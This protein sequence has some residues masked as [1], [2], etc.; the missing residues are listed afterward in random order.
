MNPSKHCSSPFTLYQI[1]FSCP[2]APN[3][4]PLSTSSSLPTSP[5]LPL[6]S[7]ITFSLPLIPYF[8]PC[9]LSSLPPSLLP[10]SSH[11][12]TPHVICDYRTGPSSVLVTVLSSTHV[13]CC[14]GDPEVQIVVSVPSSSHLSPLLSLLC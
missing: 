9:L 6:P 13:H 8:H 7:L 4:T 5:S 2:L 14:G 1:F 11:H 12:V 10:P 3:F